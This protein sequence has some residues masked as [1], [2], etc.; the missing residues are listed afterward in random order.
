MVRNRNRNDLDD[1]FQRLARE[2]PGRLARWIRSST[3]QPAALTF[4]AEAL[5]ESEDSRMVVHCLLPLLEHPSSVVREGAIYGLA[6]H[7]EH[8]G[9]RK[10]L[11]DI[12][13][14]DSR[15]GVRQAAL[16]ALA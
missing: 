8:P 16:E 1:E 15:E 12:A 13:S 9:V 10:R 6:N 3:L 7:L 14:G 4:A 11:Q 5:G 2:H